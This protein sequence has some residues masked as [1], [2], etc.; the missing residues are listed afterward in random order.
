M[1]AGQGVFAISGFQN[2][3]H[4]MFG[5]DDRSLSFYIDFLSQSLYAGSNGIVR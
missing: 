2:V 4:S 1:K 3:A 5:G